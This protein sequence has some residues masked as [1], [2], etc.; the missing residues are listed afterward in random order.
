[1]I[2]L[3][4]ASTG[5]ER[6]AVKAHQIGVNGLAFSPDGAVLASAGLDRTVKLWDVKDLKERQ[7]FR[8]HTDRVL[9]VAFFRH[10]QAIVSSGQDQ[11]VRIW[12]VST[13]KVKLILTGHGAGVEMVAISPNDKIVATASWDGTIRL[14]DAATGKEQAILKG[15]QPQPF[16][17][18]AFSPD[19]TR[20]AGAGAAGTVTLWDLK[21]KQLTQTLQPHKQTVWSLAFSPDG[22]FL[23]SGSIDTTA[24]LWDMKAAK[25]AATLRTSL[26][27]QSGQP[28]LGLAHAARWP[29]VCNGHTGR[30]GT[31]PRCEDR[32]STIRLAG[33]YEGGDLPGVRARWSDHGHKQPGRD[34]QGLGSG[35]RQ[36]KTYLERPW[37]RRAGRGLH[38]GWQEIGQCR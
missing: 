3:R 23:A 12:D 13:G 25:D 2:K 27:G 31:E 15:L 6:A 19:G 7:V 32:R 30:D 28:V 8:G 14:W 20:L 10:G 16:Q 18:L 29:G 37:R 5:E 9:S 21:T 38:R 11:T 17:A 4:D 26:A 34:R 36:R 22:N 24:K 35:H 33:P 1:M